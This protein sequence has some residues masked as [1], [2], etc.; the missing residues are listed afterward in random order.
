VP[1]DNAHFRVDDVAELNALLRTIM[2]AKFNASPSDE[3]VSWSPLVADMANR[4]ADALGQIPRRVPRPDPD[5]WRST[6]NHSEKVS[7]VRT[8][9]LACEAWK[10]W[11]EEQRADQVRILLAPL[12]PD[13]SLVRELVELGR[14]VE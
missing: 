9:I 14:A 8:R 4:V 12:R 10:D 13:E 6:Q 3:L 1:D 2:E 7:A 11:S 5:G